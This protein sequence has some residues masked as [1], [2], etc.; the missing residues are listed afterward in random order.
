MAWWDSAL[1]RRSIQS[2]MRVQTPEGKRLGRVLLIGRDVLYVR[3]WRFS[4]REFAVPLSRV[5]GVTGGAVY[6]TGAPSELREPVGDRV[7]HDIPTHVHPL[8]E[9]A[10]TGHASA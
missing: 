5:T 7:L 10:S 4:R 3:P 1:E 8:A 2:G 6:V 9:P